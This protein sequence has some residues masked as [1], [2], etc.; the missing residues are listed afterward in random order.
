MQRYNDYK[1]SGIELLNKV[2]DGWAVKKLKFG[3]QVN[4][5]KGAIDKNSQDLVTF[6]PMDKVTDRGHIDCSIKRPIS[7]LF[8]GFTFFRKNDVIL[9]KIT[10]CFENGKGALL[11][12][13]DTD[14]GFGSTEFHVLRSKQNIDERFLFYVTKSHLFMALGEASMAGA[15]GQKR[16]PTEFISNFNLATPLKKEQAVI[17]NY[18]DQKTVEIDNL[19]KQKQQLITLY[20]EEKNALI[21]QTVTKGLSPNIK[22]KDSGVEWL[23]EIPNRWKVKKLKHL[24]EQ[25]ESG[26]SVNSLDE[27]ATTGNAGILKTSCVYHYEFDAKKNKEILPS[28]LSR[29]KVSPRKGCIIIS[30]M[31]T[32]ELVG[33]SGYVQE[34]HPDLFLPDRLWQTVLFKS[35]EINTKWLAQILKSLPFRKYLSILATGTSPSMKNLGQEDFLNMKVP[36]IDINE[37]N[38]IVEYIEIETTRINKKITKTQRI[39]ELQQ[40]YRTALIS[41]AVTGKFKVPELVAKELN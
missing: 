17:A 34:N 19:I 24:I 41:E 1:D 30:R 3:I 26:V 38:L 31:N 2:P 4:P 7:E 5:A 22:M 25:L 40:E 36:F 16:V 8:S 39:I 28:E 23:G 20:Q 14:I 35:A 33:A 37:Q 12:K 13:L 6:L 18:L 15:G 9:A 10:P 29:A 11:N 21:N 32:P 27:A